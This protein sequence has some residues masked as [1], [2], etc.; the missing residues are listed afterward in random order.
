M[1]D[2]LPSLSALAWDLLLRVRVCLPWAIFA[3]CACNSGKS[4]IPNACRPS[5]PA[6]G[7]YNASNY[8]FVGI[9]LA[10][11]NNYWRKSNIPLKTVG[12]PEHVHRRPCWSNR[13]Y[14]S[15]SY[16]IDDSFYR[17]YQWCLIKSEFL[18]RQ[19]QK[20]F[21]DFW[22]SVIHHQLWSVDR[23]KLWHHGTNPDILPGLWWVRC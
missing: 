4:R 21:P 5:G 17:Y 14:P 3:A 6:V 8:P 22:L 10:L 16:H 2:G 18:Q 13:G 15:S 12:T 20:S 23:R 19:V 7:N 9:P 11:L 1:K